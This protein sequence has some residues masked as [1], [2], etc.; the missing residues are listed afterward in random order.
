MPAV[1]RGSKTCK[2]SS[3]AV[4]KLGTHAASRSQP[5]RHAGILARRL[6]HSEG[7]SEGLNCF[8]EAERLPEPS[9]IAAAS[10]RWGRRRTGIHLACRVGP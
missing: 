6:R 5:P 7:K 9:I 10:G 1:N 2:V 4:T 3:R 8:P